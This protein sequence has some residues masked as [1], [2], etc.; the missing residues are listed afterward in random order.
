MYVGA[1]LAQLPAKVTRTLAQEV[2]GR[3][4]VRNLRSYPA[5]NQGSPVRDRPTPDGV[6]SSFPATLKRA[7]ARFRVSVAG[8]LPPSPLPRSKPGANRHNTTSIK[9]TTRAPRTLTQ[10]QLLLLT[11]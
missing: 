7:T 4:T 1:T 9:H 5:V 10:T 11:D 6:V 3:I 2:L 8:K